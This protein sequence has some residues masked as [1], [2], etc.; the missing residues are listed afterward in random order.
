MEIPDLRRCEGR[1][2][3]F[4]VDEGGEVEAGEGVEFWEGARGAV[5][6][7][8]G[9]GGGE[10]GFWGERGKLTL[11]GFGWCCCNLEPPWE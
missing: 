8:G 9:G 5:D 7:V 4:D 6:F 10:V 11:R 2:G 1:P 3:V